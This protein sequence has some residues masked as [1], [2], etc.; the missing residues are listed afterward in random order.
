M[1]QAAAYGA[2]IADLDVG[3]VAD[4]GGDQRMAARHAGIALHGAVPGHGAHAQRAVALVGQLA[5]RRN[6]VQVDQQI[7]RGQAQ[8]QHGDEALPARQQLGL[9]PPGCQRLHGG[10]Q[11]GRPEVLKHRGFQSVL[12]A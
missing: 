7:G 9:V 3:D 11:R 10:L 5:Q 8:V 6:G 1:A 12:S 2:A 4:H